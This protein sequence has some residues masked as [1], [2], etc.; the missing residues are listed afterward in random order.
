M[1]LPFDMVPTFVANAFTR[2]SAF[3]GNPAAVCLLPNWPT[4]SWLGQ[5]AEQNNLSETAFVVPR[6]GDWEIRWFTPTVEVRLCGHATLAA[7]HILFSEEG[8]AGTDIRFRS[9][10]GELMVRRAGSDNYQLDFPVQELEETAES[11]LEAA[12]GCKIIYQCRGGEDLLVE[13]ESEQAVANAAPDTGRLAQ[14]DFRGVVITARGDECDFVSRFFGP[15]CGVPEDPVTG[16]AHCAL[17]PYW[18]ERLR[19][20][21]MRAVQLSPRGGEIG[22]RLKDDRVLLTGRCA[23]YLRGNIT[24]PGERS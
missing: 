24:T 5:V 22:V 12:F 18:S 15:N 10:S 7:G 9:A 8:V 11:G 20:T 13:L 23:T 3:S 6:D 17:A 4:E 19:R 2:D 1:L 14:Y 16:S 21:E